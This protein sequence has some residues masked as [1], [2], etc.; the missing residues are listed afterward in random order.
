MEDKKE[1]LLS[2][3][4]ANVTPVLVDFIS[5]SDL[6]GAVVLPANIDVKEL[7]G[8]YEE[9]EFVA[10]KWFK[11]ITN[12]NAIYKAIGY[13]LTYGIDMSGCMLLTSGKI[14]K[15]NVRACYIS[16]C[17]VLVSQSPPTRQAIEYAMDKDVTL[18]CCRGDGSFQ[19]YCGWERIMI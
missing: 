11:D 7:N 15:E 13:S 12:T 14:V 16:G 1:M 18:I 3:I 9:A 19:V 17:H 5:G 2:Y 10:P 8:Y 6:S 4:K